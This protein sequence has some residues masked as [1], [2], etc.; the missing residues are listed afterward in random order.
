MGQKDAAMQQ[1]VSATSS[2]GM[3]GGLELGMRGSLPSRIRGE[4]TDETAPPE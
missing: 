2:G 1:A 3:L 4:R